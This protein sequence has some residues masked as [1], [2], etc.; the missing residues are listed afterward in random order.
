MSRLR[1]TVLP[2]PGTPR[3][4]ATS[5][6][7]NTVGSGLYLPTS[8]LY[9]THVAGLP[10]ARVG[11]GLTVAGLVALTGSVPIGGLADRYGPRRVLAVVL[12]VQC[13]AM[14]SFTSV[15]SFPAFLVSAMV[16]TLADQGSNAARGALVAAAGKGAERVRLRAYLRVVTNLG[17]GAG[18]GL[19]A[20]AVQADSASW[21]TALLTVNAATFVGAAVPLWWLPPDI[22]CR[23]HEPGERQA[24]PVSRWQVLRDARYVCTTAVCGV[25][26]LQLQVMSFAVP[27]WVADHTSAPKV[28]ASVIVV[29]N[30]VMVV[31]FQMRASRGAED[32]GRAAALCR[33]A[34]VALLAAC[35]VV[36]LTSGRGTAAT[37]GLLLV[38]AVLLTL[39]ELWTS[40]GGFGLS[41][42]LAPESAHGQYQGF[43]SLGKGS[44]QAVAPS[45]LAA[46][47]L[48]THPTVGWLALGAL[49]AVAGLL[50][51]VVVH[52]IPGTRPTPEPP[53]SGAPHALPQRTH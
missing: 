46:L 22:G 36:A 29:V 3:L 8:A 13:A 19:A 40:A 14:F 52:R 15:R 25:L 47:C 9:F 33:R 16:F 17:M 45:L 6:L 18:A 23:R 7:V 42:N 30:A 51:P 39:G 44:S 43:Y 48:G 11:I 27:L 20:L 32:D 2:A 35:A 21:Y 37:V 49:F 41:F 26:N 1:D 10:V 34:G 28:M 53:R 4:L 38:F 5:W 31:L 50:M 12:A 24:P